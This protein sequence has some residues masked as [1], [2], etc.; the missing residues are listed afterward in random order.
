MGRELY[1][2]RVAEHSPS[3][4]DDEVQASSK[5]YLFCSKITSLATSFHALLITSTSPTTIPKPSI[6]PTPPSTSPSP[7]P[8]PAPSTPLLQPIPPCKIVSPTP[9]PPRIR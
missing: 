5:M 2:L 7:S 4:I 1:L 8:S 6:Q 3:S 9:L